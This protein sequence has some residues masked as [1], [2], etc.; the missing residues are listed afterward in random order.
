VSFVI[1]VHNGGPFI[2]EAVQSAL[3]QRYPQLEVVAI[4]DGSSDASAEI[5]ARVAERDR[6]VRLYRRQRRGMA[7]ALNEAVGLARGDLIARL[8]ADDLA[9]PDRLC[10]QVAVLASEPRL[11]AVGGAAVFI[12]GEGREFARYS[13]PTSPQETALSLRESCQLVHSAVTLRREAFEQVGGYRPALQ[14]AAD[15]DLWLRLADHYQLSN[16]PQAVVAYRVHPGMRSVEHLLQGTLCSVAAKTAARLRR[17]TGCDP[18]DGIERVT[19]EIL[20]ELGVAP[21]DIAREH[22]RRVSWLAR[23]MARAGYREVAEALLE[24]HASP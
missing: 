11:A 2:E 7:S 8:D 19:P 21:V 13:Y 20:G 10:H 18:I 22:E 17:E 15:Y 9:F 3:R 5:L 24:G 14:S 4:D 16:V 6:R 12:N 23:T 1:A